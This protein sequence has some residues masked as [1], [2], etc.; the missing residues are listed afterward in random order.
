MHTFMQSSLH[1]CWVAI[2]IYTYIYIDICSCWCLHDL[3]ILYA[4]LA[5]KHRGKQKKT[6][7]VSSSPGRIEG[8]AGKLEWYCW[9]KKSDVHQLEVGSLSKSHSLQ[10]FYTSQVVGWDFFHQQYTW[11]TQV[12]AAT[13]VS[14]FGSVGSS[15]G[16]FW[17][18]FY[19]NKILGLLMI[20]WQLLWMNGTRAQRSHG[21]FMSDKLES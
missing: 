9:W 3:I 12:F 4:S 15:D 19:R 21:H 1:H 5:A 17:G 13:K 2:A 16:S 8:G 10:R 11:Q 20:L 14:A 6:S 18:F 7:P